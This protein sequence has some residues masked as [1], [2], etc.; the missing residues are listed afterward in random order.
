MSLAINA[1]PFDNVD[2]PIIQLQPSSN[3]QKKLR[4]NRTVKLRSGSNKISS[5]NVNSV[6]SNIHNDQPYENN[7]ASAELGDFTPLAPPVSVG[8][9]QT[10]TREESV[11]NESS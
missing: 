2:E 4:N 6:I 9:E 7:E 5:E 11:D 10:R 3:G 8:V 1:A